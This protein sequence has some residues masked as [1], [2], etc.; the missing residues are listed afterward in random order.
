MRYVLI[1][2][3]WYPSRVNFLAGDFIER[4]AKAAALYFPVR[5]LYAVKDNTMPAGSVRLERNKT[6]EQYE[7]FIY[8]YSAKSSF[9]PM[10]KIIST[11]L[12]WKC[13]SNGY[14]AILASYGRPSLIHAHVLVK[15]A[16]FALRISK[17]SD[18][19]LLASEQWT[20]YLPGAEAEFNALSSFQRRTIGKVL[21]HAVH[22]TTVSDYLAKKMK[23]I[24]RFNGYTVIPN[25]VDTDI[26]S[27]PGHKNDVTTFIH[28]ST[29]SYQKNFDEVLDACVIL[30]TNASRFRLI[31]VSPPNGF[32]Q[33]KVSALG[34]QANIVFKNEVPQAELS[35]LVA[36]ADALILYS[37]YETFGCVIVEA[38]ACGVP[39]IT[40]DCPVFEENVVEAETGF[41]VALHNPA[42]LA[43]RM[44]KIINKH[45]S[46]NKQ[47]IID[48]TKA[49]YSIE[50]VGKQFAAVYNQYAKP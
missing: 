3:G 27:G 33:N 16:W 31:V 22:V 11:W 46:F 44:Q 4:H 10:E 28:V 32:Y 17:K 29:L 9:R 34:L 50:V 19:P 47:R 2:P 26:F 40:S 36:S 8:Y 37:N 12:Q 7:A 15:H 21:A 42:L 45:H 25:L 30:K 1:I 24:F 35:Q 49:H 39:V 5:V 41:R 48:R 20:G 43:D 38:N 6:S 18:I 23:D 13:L 14:K